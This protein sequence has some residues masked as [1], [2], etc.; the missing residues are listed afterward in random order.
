MS[1]TWGNEEWLWGLAFPALLLAWSIFHR[2]RASAKSKSSKAQWATTGFGGVKTTK[3]SNVRPPKFLLCAALALLV[4][5]IARPRWGT[6]TQV[7][8]ERSREV[9]IAMDLSK[10]MLADD[11]KPNRLDRAKLVVQS[12]L[13][14]LEG[15]SVGLIVFA[16]TAFLQS[17]MS[18][19]YQILRGF[20]DDIKPSFIPQGGTNYAAMMDT[21]LE[22]FEQ[23]DGM[24]DRFLIIISDGESLDSTW[25]AKAQELKEQNVRTICLGF[26]TK[27]GSFIPDGNGSYLKN[28]QGAVVLSKLE[29]ATLTQ[30]ARITNGVYREANVW[31]D[32]ADLVEETV[33][34]GR[35][36]L[37]ER[38]REES[39]IERYHYF[40]A[41]GFALLLVSIYLEFPT[42]PQP[43]TIKRKA[44]L[45]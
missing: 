5:S 23:S 41:P 17:P 7:T 21:A 4:V 13:E 1:I 8:F 16:G 24:A 36:S 28:P 38:E 9:I 30:I 32:L 29:P 31:I 6:D 27:E 2:N 14:S 15:E 10:S 3:R 35:V 43:R 40:L 44:N 33:K 19:D 25:V 18:P 45:A 11:I 26:G 34:T 39:Q 37:K 42:L 12:M 22:S 20:L